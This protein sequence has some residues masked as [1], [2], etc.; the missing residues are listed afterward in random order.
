MRG[1]CLGFLLILSPEAPPAGGGGGRGKRGQKT[2]QLAAKVLPLRIT[3]PRMGVQSIGSLLQDI[4]SFKAVSYLLME[5]DPRPALPFPKVINFLK[6]TESYLGLYEYS[7]ATRMFYLSHA[8][9][10][11]TVLQLFSERP[12][13][14]TPTHGATWFGTQR[15][16]D[17]EGSEQ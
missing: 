14:W 1:F 13:S 12:L 7:G 17:G 11:L 6:H 4:L 15:G 2:E 8:T 3:G 5:L 9:P 10:S 16:E